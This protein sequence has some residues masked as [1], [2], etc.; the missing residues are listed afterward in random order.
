MSRVYTDGGDP[1]FVMDQISDKKNLE[2]NWVEDLSL[3]EAMK[4]LPERERHIIDMRFFEGKNPD[5]GC[6]GNPYQPGPGEPP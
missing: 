2:E 6:P 3:V 4:R 5:R 1:H